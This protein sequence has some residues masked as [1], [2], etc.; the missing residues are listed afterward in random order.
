MSALTHPATLDL[1]WT[2][3]AAGGLVGLGALTLF[4]LPWTDREIARMDSAFRS[5]GEVTS[6]SIPLHTAG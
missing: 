5:M 1:I 4:A 2:L 6:E 3:A